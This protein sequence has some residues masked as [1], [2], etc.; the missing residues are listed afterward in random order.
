MCPDVVGGETQ[1]LAP[2]MAGSALTTTASGVAYFDDDNQVGLFLCYFW[3]VNMNVLCLF[4]CAW[5]IIRV[6]LTPPFFFTSFRQFF[7]SQSSSVLCLLGDTFNVALM[8]FGK[9][10][11]AAWKCI[12]IHFYNRFVMSYTCCMVNELHVRSL[13]WVWLYG[14]MSGCRQVIHK[15]R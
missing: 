4:F 5:Y 14:H 2:I 10:G 3:V 7:E 8:L 15:A 6:M 13:L 11:S 12:K 1:T 9:Q